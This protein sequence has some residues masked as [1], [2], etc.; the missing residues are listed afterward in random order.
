MQS[1]SIR[2]SHTSSTDVL[3]E[4]A[5]ILLSQAD[6]LAATASRS[7]AAAFIGFHLDDDERAFSHI[8]ASRVDLRRFPISRIFY[9]A[10][11]F[12]TRPQPD[13]VMG[14]E[15]H[16][17]RTFMF[18]SPRSGP[19]SAVSRLQQRF[20]RPYGLCRTVSDAAVARWKLE[21]DRRG[22]FT[23]RELALL[24]DV[25][26]TAALRSIGR[27]RKERDHDAY[28]STYSTLK[29]E[30]AMGWLSEQPGF[31]SSWKLLKEDPRVQSRFAEVRP[32][33]ALHEFVQVHRMLFVP[34]EDIGR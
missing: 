27:W 28:V 6:Q 23:V 11:S 24:A 8:P 2:I 9:D 34:H 20:M 3:D 5:K 10:V 12:V 7:A 17:L 15:V 19:H 29:F 1:T 33:E 22:P 32:T 16:Q 25:S 14:E 13:H 30:E 26:D 4:L 21:V 31:V 18:H